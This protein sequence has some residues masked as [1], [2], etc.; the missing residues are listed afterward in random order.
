M[1]RP[2]YLYHGAAILNF[3]HWYQWG[4]KNKIVWFLIARWLWA[5]IVVIRY[6]EHDQD[7]DSIIKVYCNRAEIQSG[8]RPLHMPALALTVTSKTSIAAD[9]ENFFQTAEVTSKPLETQKKCFNSKLFKFY[10]R[11]N[12]T[13]KRTRHIHDINRVEKTNPLKF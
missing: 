11:F 6:E 12:R 1:Y 9:F 3:A 4:W 2:I 10:S 13:L 5:C 7:G 8:I